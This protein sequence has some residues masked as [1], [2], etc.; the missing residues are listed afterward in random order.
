M[1]WESIPR[2]VLS[3]GDRFGDAESVVDGPLRLTFAELADRVRVAAG[4][5]ASAGIGKGDRAAIW[6]PNSADW[7]VAAF[8]L[9]T[10]GGVLV[11][12]NTRFK[13]DEAGDII[14]RSGAK[15]VLVEKG[16]LGLD[17]AAEK[18]AAPRVS[19]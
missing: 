3:G 2:M 15:A 9:L 16:F 6:A 13:A 18:G 12:V 5:F 11:P 7:I 17:Y 4:A 14:G 10:A 1:T 19:R 8:G